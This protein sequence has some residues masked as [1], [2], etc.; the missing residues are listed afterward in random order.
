MLY[1]RAPPA[2]D[3]FEPLR[4]FC[5]VPRV[6][7]GMHSLISEEPSM[8]CAIGGVSVKHISRH[9]VLR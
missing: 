2:I 3:T 7:E 8:Y 9:T 4:S 1:L 5:F 6:G